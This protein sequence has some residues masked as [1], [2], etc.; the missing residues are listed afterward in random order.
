MWW[1]INWYNQK[2]SN[3]IIIPDG[4]LRFEKQ[5]QVEEAFMGGN[6]LEERL[7]AYMHVII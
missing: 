7:F 1:I 3:E 5:T 6:V 2:S 4:I